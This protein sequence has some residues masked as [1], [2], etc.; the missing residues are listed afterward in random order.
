MK[1]KLVDERKKAKKNENKTEK[2][3]MKPKQ[4]EVIAFLFPLLIYIHM[5]PLSMTVNDCVTNWTNSN[6]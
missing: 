2:P 5:N 1:R 4:F 6:H 3:I